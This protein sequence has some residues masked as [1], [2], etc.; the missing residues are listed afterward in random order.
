MKMKMLTNFSSNR[1]AEIKNRYC[2][3]TFTFQKLKWPVLRR[4][5][6]QDTPVTC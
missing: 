2:F 6:N 3:T 1:E 5:W 4:I